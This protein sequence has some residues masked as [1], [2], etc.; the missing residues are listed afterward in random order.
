[1]ADLINHNEWVVQQT[2]EPVVTADE[3]REEYEQEHPPPDPAPDAMN[4]WL[5]VVDNTLHLL[6]NHLTL[7]YLS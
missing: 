1:V 5:P 7:A 2:V 3:L 6:I 4:V